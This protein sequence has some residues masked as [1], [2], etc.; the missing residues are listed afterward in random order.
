MKPKYQ[1]TFAYSPST[2]TLTKAELADTPITV[3]FYKTAKRLSIRLL[4]FVQQRMAQPVIL[5]GAREVRITV[6]ELRRA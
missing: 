2:M 4:C 1:L 6:N 3:W 5:R